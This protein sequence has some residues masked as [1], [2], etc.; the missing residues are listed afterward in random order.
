MN[1]LERVLANYNDEVAITRALALA[2][3]IE[4]IEPKDTIYTDEYGDKI[5]VITGGSAENGLGGCIRTGDAGVLLTSEQALSLAKN[6]WPAAKKDAEVL[7]EIA[8]I[9][10]A[11]R[12]ADAEDMDAIGNLVTGTGRSI[13]TEKVSL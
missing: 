1:T 6:L 4:Y 11:G 2:E 5:E 7:D 3:G 9:F 8:A 13:E 12:F 10:R